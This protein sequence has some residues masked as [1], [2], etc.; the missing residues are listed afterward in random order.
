MNHQEKSIWSEVAANL[1][2]LIGY[3]YWLVTQLMEFAPEAI[4]YR[5]VLFSV[6]LFHVLF[7]IVAQS[8]LAIADHRNANLVDVRDVDIR[9]KANSAAFHV[10]SVTSLI[11]LGLGLFEVGFFEIVHVLFFGGLL[12][13]LSVNG[14]K[15][16]FYRVGL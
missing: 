7:S 14:L 16:W 11:A 6:F 3:S 4:D 2:V 1:A 12:A 10:M 5:W 8:L 9:R 15:L 13:S